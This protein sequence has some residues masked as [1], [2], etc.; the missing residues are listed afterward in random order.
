MRLTPGQASHFGTIRPALKCTPTLCPSEWMAS[1]A[2]RLR[3]GTRCSCLGW[4]DYFL[5]EVFA[6]TRICARLLSR[7]LLKPQ[8]PDL[9]GT[10]HQHPA[11]RRCKKTGFATL[12][13]R[14]HPYGRT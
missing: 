13:Q 14:K 11:L 1:S 3:P 4:S 10:T 12:V 8:V 5:V 7:S 2:S 6:A 9:T